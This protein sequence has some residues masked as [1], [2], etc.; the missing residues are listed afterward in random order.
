[1]RKKRLFTIIVALVVVATVTSVTGYL[2]TRRPI[3]LH[4]FIYTEPEKAPDFTL[5][6][7]NGQPFT[8][9]DQRG[10]VVLLFFGY[11]YCPD[12]CPTIMTQFNWILE[13]LGSDKNKVAF[14]LVTVDPLR[15]TPEVLKNYVNSHNDEIIGLTGSLENLEPVWISYGINVNATMTHT[16][17]NHPHENDYLVDHT[18]LLFINDKN[19]MLREEFLIGWSSNE[20]ILADIQTL[21]N[22]V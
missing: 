2:S 6:D 16:S 17:Q 1:M 20:I 8:L 18:I 4:G 14:V 10:K 3:E 21:L 11:T 7:H 22:E 13:N 19:L 12:T 5:T 9:S 15:D